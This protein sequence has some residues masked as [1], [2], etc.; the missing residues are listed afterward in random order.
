MVTTVLWLAGVELGGGRRGEGFGLRSQDRAAATR[1]SRV[2]LRMED[3]L[4]GEVGESCVIVNAEE[5]DDS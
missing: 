1:A 3:M 4:G 2:M 5:C